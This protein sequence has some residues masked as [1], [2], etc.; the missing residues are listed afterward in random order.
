[1]RII[2][3]TPYA[4][5]N[6]IIW[7][8]EELGLKYDVN[9]VDPMKGETKMPEHL[10]RNPNG[11]IPVLEKDGFFIWET[12]AINFYLAK[13]YGNG[14]LWASDPHEEAKIMQWCVFGASSLDKPAVNY[15][16]HKQA[17]P[18]EMR[19]AE[20]LKDAEVAV[21]VYAKILDDHLADKDYLVGG[22]FTIADLNLSAILDYPRKSGYVLS[23]Y[24]N[25]TAWLSRCLERPTRIQ[26]GQRS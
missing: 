24:K 23:P 4:R 26:M 1:M 2:H 12:A 14:I 20:C 11:L 8:M 3:G 9:P 18:E 17:F 6:Y 13:N 5:T 16:L 22:R 15:I 19:D 7:A 21:A 25:L 10:E